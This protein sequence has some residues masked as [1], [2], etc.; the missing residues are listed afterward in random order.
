MEG[1]ELC[2]HYQSKAHM[3]GGKKLGRGAYFYPDK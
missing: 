3:C 1:Y 2:G